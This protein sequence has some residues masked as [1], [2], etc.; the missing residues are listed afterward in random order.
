MV[1]AG[2]GR[3]LECRRMEMLRVR[4]VTGIL[5]AFLL[6]PLTGCVSPMVV[7]EEPSFQVKSRNLKHW[8][9]LARR[10]VNGIRGGVEGTLY[11]QD[12]MAN[13]DFGSAFKSLLEQRFLDRGFA[14]ATSGQAETTVRFCYQTYLYP[15]KR[16]YAYW[17]YAT[18]PWVAP[19]IPD[20]YARP[21]SYRF[22]ASYGPIGI[23]GLHDTLLGPGGIGSITNAE[24]LLKAQ[25]TGP[26]GEIVS[27]Y[28]E[29]LY[30]EPEDIPLFGGLQPAGADICGRPDR[31]PELVEKDF[32][33]EQL[34]SS[35]PEGASSEVGLEQ[36]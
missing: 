4:I 5:G 30:I 34:G 26:G 20:F 12:G 2:I 1:V 21:D 3:P 8:E 36:W 25:I 18:R 16:A 33:G 13:G 27:S 23:P 35:R 15:R 7:P 11:V 19:T 29:R 22:R 28:T 6:A 14:V 32:R 10:V 24:L 31:R 9:D 17:S